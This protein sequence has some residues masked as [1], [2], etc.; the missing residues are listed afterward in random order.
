M[1]HPRYWTNDSRL[2]REGLAKL[3]ARGLDGIEAVYQANE[4]GDTVDHLRAAKELGLCVTAGSDFH[5][6][7]KPEI[8]IGME[9]DDERAFLAPF[10]ER[11]SV[12]RATAGKEAL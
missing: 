1:A 7:N 4:P 10:F 12:R 3:K 5:G 2:L 6:S 11:L 8:S 9:V